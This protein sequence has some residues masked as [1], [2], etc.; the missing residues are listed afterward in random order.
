ML[1]ME[2]IHFDFASFTSPFWSSR[3]IVCLC[4]LF[5]RHRLHSS[6]TIRVHLTTF[7]TS[8]DVCNVHESWVAREEMHSANSRSC[9]LCVR[10]LS[11]THIFTHV[12]LDMRKKKQTPYLP[13]VYW[14][15]YCYRCIDVCVRQFYVYVFILCACFASH[16]CQS[17]V[18]FDLQC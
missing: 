8:I 15:C 3:L 7:H 14:Y 2:V 4:L 13:Y 1:I 17:L 10:T 5:Y 12:M 11:R 18:L 6:T 9:I 16:W